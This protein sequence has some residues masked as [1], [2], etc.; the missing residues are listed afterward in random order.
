VTSSVRPRAG[1]I[2]GFQPVSFQRVRSGRSFVQLARGHVGTTITT[3]NG[4]TGRRR[5]GLRLS[6]VRGVYRL[7]PVVMFQKDKSS[8]KLD[9][10]ALENSAPRIGIANSGGS[11]CDPYVPLMPRIELPFSTL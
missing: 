1:L 4:A 11:H 7:Q 9:Q 5:R 2:T 3:V 6:V 8:P 10:A